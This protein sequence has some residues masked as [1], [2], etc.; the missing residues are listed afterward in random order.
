MSG[1]SRAVS[2]IGGGVKQIGNFGGNLSNNNVT[3][4]LTGT[5]RNSG[6]MGLGQFQ[7]DAYRANAAAFGPDAAEQQYIQGLQNAVAG[8]GPSVAEQQMM[9]GLDQSNA[10]AQSMAAS[11][12]GISPALAARLAAQQQSAM[13]QSTNAN[14]AQLRAEEQMNA[15]NSL[16]QGLQSLRAGRMGLENLNAGNY[17][18][19]Q[20][21]NLQ[22]YANAAG[23]RADFM[24]GL[25]NSIGGGMQGGGGGGGGGMM[26]M[27]GSMG[28]AGGGEIPDP[29]SMNKTPNIP[30]LA[31][32]TAAYNVQKEGKKGGKPGEE[33]KAGFNGEKAPYGGDMSSG[34]GNM[35]PMANGASFGQRGMAMGGEVPAASKAGQFLAQPVQQ[36]GFGGTIRSIARPFMRGGGNVRVQEQPMQVTPMPRGIAVK[37]QQPGQPRT[38]MVPNKAPVGFDNG[39]VVPGTAKVAGDSLKNDKVP[40]LLSPKEIVLPRSVTLAEDAPARAAE[41]VAAV[42]A[43]QSAKKGKAS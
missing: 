25:M 9:R 1:I 18:Y 20:G 43:R 19:A 38:A 7:S 29:G 26:S 33:K 42:K 21:L 10:Q 31:A 2:T 6:I 24:G 39:G 28:G 40:A 16:G 5:G 8:N 4:W 11:Q 23:H 36:M 15:R 12:R 41:F 22:G 34:S 17:N 37:G 30:Q 32:V 3:G 14:A 35:S 27:M 13:N